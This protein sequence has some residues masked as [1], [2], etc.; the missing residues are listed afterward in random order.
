MFSFDGSTEGMSEGFI[1][2]QSSVDGDLDLKRLE[3]ASKAVK[4][5]V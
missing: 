3:I 2:C 5:E 1:W 4:A